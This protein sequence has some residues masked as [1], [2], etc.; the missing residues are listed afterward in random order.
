MRHCYRHAAALALVGW[1]LM[2]PP[3][4][5]DARDP[6]PNE[7]APMSQW[8]LHDSFDTAAECR[9]A[10]TLEEKR[11]HGMFVKQSDPPHNPFRLHSGLAELSRV[12]YRQMLAAECIA[13]DDPR[14]KEK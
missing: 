6:N 4:P 2:V 10:K 1:Y 5:Q 8:S 7:K 12:L 14:L 3:P 13:T 11:L 9:H